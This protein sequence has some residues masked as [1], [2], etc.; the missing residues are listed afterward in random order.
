MKLGGMHSLEDLYF[1]H[2]LRQLAG[3]SGILTFNIYVE[4]IFSG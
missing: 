3:T 4:R 1:I 2:N